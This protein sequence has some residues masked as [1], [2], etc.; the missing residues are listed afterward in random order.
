[1]DLVRRDMEVIKAPVCVQASL[2]GHESLI[3]ARS[4]T[5]KQEYEWTAAHAAHAGTVISI[6][7]FIAK[8]LLST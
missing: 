5:F 2:R 1:M 8:L 4:L 7:L 6:L 3:G